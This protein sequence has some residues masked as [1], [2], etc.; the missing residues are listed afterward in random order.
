MRRHALLLLIHIALSCLLLTG[1][2]LA[3]R[4]QGGQPVYDEA[5]ING[6]QNWSWCTVDFASTDY[7]LVGTH[8]AKITYT[9]GWQ[10]F[11]LHHAPFDTS[12]YSALTFWIH[13]GTVSGRNILVAGLIDDAQQPGVPLNNYVEGGAVGAGEWRKVTI[14]LDA[15]HIANKSNVTGFWLQENTGSAQPAFYVDD[16]VFT[17]SAPPAIVHLGVDAGR[18]RRSVDARLFGV[19]TAVWDAVFNT[20]ETIALLKAAQIQ[21]LRFPGG[22]LS[23][24]YHWRTNTTDSNTWQWAT[25]F[26]AFARVARAVGAQVFITANYGSG[27]PQEAADWVAYANVTQG[28]GFRYWEIGNEVYGSWEEDN[29]AHPHDPYT[30]ATLAGDYITRMKAADPNIKVGVVVVPGEDSYVN[31]TD[32]PATNPRTGQTHNGWTPVLLATLKA[33]GVTPDFVIHHRYEQNP[34]EE[35]DAAL[36]QS[37]RSWKADS[38]DLRRQLTDYLGAA[39]ARVEL[40][41]TENNSVS[42]NPGKQTTSLVNGLFLADSIGSILES[43][44][45][46]LIWWNLHNAQEADHNNA[47]SLYGWRQYGDYGIVSPTNE[48]YPTYYLQKLLA[49]FARGG[50]QVVAA[51]SDYLLLSI[52]A[53]RRING[54]LSLLVINKSPQVALN[55][56]IVLHGFVPRAKAHVYAYGIPQDEAARTG[57][58]SPDIQQTALLN[59]GPSFMATFP[60]YSATVISLAPAAQIWPV[61]PVKIRPLGGSPTLRH[62]GRLR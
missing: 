62:G 6:W 35:S 46:A 53:V 18:I 41:C 59:A 50:D 1:F 4:A 44:F 31:Y 21:A 51:S 23:D 30:Y 39:G 25:G 20:P 2:A 33:L 15:L 5:L 19:N 45:N 34:G 24:G 28:Y 37:A 9:G 57:V 47:P 8:S 36:L 49:H 17:G 26:D 48:P 38:A 29:H 13:G 7:A 56:E 3:A 10:G 54:M 27:T 61:G 58:G 60:P 40:L 11:Y 52:Y 32:H 43:E 55:A 12:L 16:V 42:Y 22:S 14:P